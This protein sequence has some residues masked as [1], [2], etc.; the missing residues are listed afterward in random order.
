MATAPPGT[1]G[2]LGAVVVVHGGQSLST[3]PTS[4]IQLSVLRMVPVARAIRHALRGS[5]IVVG[6]PRLRLRGWNGADASPV[7]DL[8][9]LLD[10]IGQRHGPVPIVLIGHS[11]GGR[12]ALRV[13][14]HPL[15]SAVAGLAPWVPPGEPVEQ[16][17]GRRVLLAHGTADRVTSP[18]ETWAY[19]DRARG[20]GPVATIEVHHGEHALL[21]RAR[22]W[23]RIAADF[24]RISFA[25]P[26]RDGALTDA[27]AGAG[28]TV[29]LPAGPPGLLA[30]LPARHT[31]SCGITGPATA[32]RS[33]P[34]APAAPPPAGPAEGEPPTHALG[35][36]L[37]HRA[38]LSAGAG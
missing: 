31:R 14:G 23:H 37:P 29:L 22:L 10:G 21:R 34:T 25:L 7:D 16:L 36:G 32:T 3:E 1:P 24:T 8:T 30:G 11:M 15:V 4:A 12:A 5:G 13:A 17:A 27:C 38:E 20:I 18:A 26:T 2:I 35:R 33:S 9:A 19:A 6:R 28:H